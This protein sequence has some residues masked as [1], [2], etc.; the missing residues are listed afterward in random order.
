M[1]GFKFGTFV[2]TMAV[3]L[4]LS[5]AP[6]LAASPM[7]VVFI[8]NV[9]ANLAVL[10]ASSN[11]VHARSESSAVEAFASNE[12]A[13]ASNVAVALAEATPSDVA[14]GGTVHTGAAEVGALQ[15]GRSVAVVGKP[16]AAAPRAPTAN[17]VEA[18]NGRIPPALAN[19]SRLTTLHG[20][21][22]DNLYWTVQLDA[23]SQIESDYR[24]YIRL[25][26]DPAIAKMA[27]ENLPALMHRLEALTKI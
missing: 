6:A 5:Q 26:D 25:G 8:S 17:P 13:E 21:A 2:S 15:T 7:T 3:S 11:L 10:N 27:R 16:E 18:A 20:A 14:M 1:A 4:A 9:A 23:L 12:M 22:F 19:L 24:T